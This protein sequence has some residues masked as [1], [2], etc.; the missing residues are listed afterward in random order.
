MPTA[1][2]AVV[3]VNETFAGRFFPNEDPIGKRITFGDPTGSATWREIVGVAANVRHFGMR[4]PGRAAL[5]LP[6]DQAPSNSLFLV[7]R[8]DRGPNALA[9][10]ARAALTDVDPLLAAG[11]I[12][13]LPTLVRDAMGPERLVASLLGMFALLALV[14]AVVGLYGVV[15]YNVNSRL[16]EMGVRLALGASGGDVGGLVV[17]ASLG[18]V[19]LGLGIGAAVALVLSRLMENLLFGVTPTDPLTFVGVAVLLAVAGGIAAAVPAMRAAR[20][21]PVRVLSG[22]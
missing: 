12:V 9:G 2:A 17:R 11:G 3:V 7:L 16:R 22:E 14:L 21:D 8:S 4:D 19:A 10:E 6:F 5:Y 20:V 18:L 13:P 1:S 15:S